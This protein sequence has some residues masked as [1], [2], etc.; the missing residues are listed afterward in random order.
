MGKRS[1]K[2]KLLAMI[3]SIGILGLGGASFTAP[4]VQAAEPPVISDLKV[5]ESGDGQGI[6]A[7]CSYQNYND[8]SG[9]EM[10]LYLYRKE[11]TGQISILARQKLSY[12][13]SGTGSTSVYQAQEGVYFASV[14]MN[15]GSEAVQ[16]YSQSYYSVKIKDGKVEVTEISET[17]GDENTGSQNKAPK[18]GGEESKS[19]ACQHNLEYKWERQATAG[20][21]GLLAYQCTICGDVIDYK[22]APN[23]AF[24]VFLKETAEKI[25]GAQA[26]EV[27][28]DTDRWMS[29]DRT[30]LEALESRRDVAVDL[31][32]QYQG[33]RY[34]VRIPAG[35]DVSGLADEN[36]YCGFLYLRQVFDEASQ[37]GE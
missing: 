17:D 6:M 5:S 18:S 16:T 10:T 15:Y 19:T 3:M 7:Q 28:I 35:E 22:E 26:K 2:K 33:Q 24:S 20:Q 23:S 32:Y 11:E 4:E 13:V 29:F 30:V 25:K 36:G 9:C 1:V 27:V 21:D 34:S 12:A 37:I 31:Y 8:Q 14:G